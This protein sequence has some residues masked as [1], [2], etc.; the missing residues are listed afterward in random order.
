VKILFI[1]VTIAAFLFP[2]SIYGET[3][4]QSIDGSKYVAVAQIEL[5]DSSDN[6]VSVTKAIASH[7]LP[8]PIVDEFLEQYEV[9]EFVELKGKVYELRQIVLTEEHPKDSYVFESTLLFQ[10]E[11]RKIEIFSGLNHAFQ[12]KSGDVSTIVWTILR[13]SN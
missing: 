9:K 11:N 10:A 1:Y 6:L 3:E 13:L 7:Y 5:R 4:P 8:D 12:V 2:T